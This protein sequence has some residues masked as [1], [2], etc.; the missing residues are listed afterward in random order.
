MD[1]STR[2]AALGFAE[3]LG[4]LWGSGIDGIVHFRLSDTY[5][6]IFG[7]WVGHGLFADARGTHAN[8]QAY[9]PFPS[10]WVFANMYRELGGGQ[11]VSVTAP[12]E[13]AVVAA[14]RGNGDSAQLAVWVTNST[15]A[16][17]NV[18]FQVT[19]FSTE[20]VKVRVL[21]NLAGDTPIETSVVSGPVL[22]LSQNIPVRSSR[23]VVF[24]PTS[25][26]HMVYLPL[27]LA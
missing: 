8:G 14:R 3:M 5:A 7:G 18:Q 12:S 19:H 15:A 1:F 23:L 25:S 4:R 2:T 16:S 10:Y 6:D 27:V 17:Y 20:M 26:P 11:V 21:D 13:L 22:T 24:T 9:A